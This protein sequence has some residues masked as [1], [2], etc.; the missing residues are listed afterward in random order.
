MLG[1]RSCIIAGREDCLGFDFLDDW[2]D[3]VGLGRGSFRELELGMKSQLVIKSSTRLIQGRSRRLTMEEKTMCRSNGV[4]KR[5]AEGV[6]GAHFR[7]TGTA[8]VEAWITRWKVL[9]LWGNLTLNVEV[10]AQATL[11]EK[12]VAE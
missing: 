11:L 5:V 9:D 3:L 2:I 12:R 7:S 6:G 4:E 10:V 1:G 8:A